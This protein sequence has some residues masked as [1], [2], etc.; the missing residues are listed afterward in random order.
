MKL[1]QLRQQRGRAYIAVSVGKRGFSKR[2]TEPR[3]QVP[4]GRSVAGRCIS[5]LPPASGR[6]CLPPLQPASGRHCLLPL[7]P[8]FGRRCLP[9]LPPASGR[10]PLSTHRHAAAAAIAAAATAPIDTAMTAP[11]NRHQVLATFFFGMPQPLST[12]LMIMISCFTDVFSGVALMNEPAETAIMKEQPRDFKRARLIDAK[13]VGYAY[14]FYAN[15]VSV[16]AFLNY[17]I[18]KENRGPTGVVPDPVPADG[19]GFTDADFPAGYVP[20][21]LI[22][23][24][25]WGIAEGPLGEDATAASNTG[26]AVFFIAIAVGQLLHHLSVRQ[27]APY[28]ANAILDLSDDGTFNVGGGSAGVAARLWMAIKQTRPVK[29]VL[30]AW[31]GAVIIMVGLTEI[32]AL[33]TL[34]GTGSVP[35]LNWGIAFGWSALCFII[36]E[37]RKWIITLHPNSSVGKSQIGVVS[38]QKAVRIKQPDRTQPLVIILGCGGESGGSSNSGFRRQHRR[39]QRRQ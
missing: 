25:N 21:Q 24:W 9:P 20:S 14:F 12:F 3:L 17:F 19:S 4:S 13:L 38:E 37:A 29:R 33:Q 1:G 18:Y 6:R 26:S 23:A 28:Y 34:C 32:P 5:P 22:F 39:R 31:T 30:L 8:T 10:L 7:P 27:K 11:T 36:A 16:G 35:P 15:L 2:V